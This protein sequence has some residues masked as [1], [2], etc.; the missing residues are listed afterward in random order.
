VAANFGIPLPAGYDTHAV[1]DPIIASIALPPFVPK[2]T[3]IKASEADT[4]V[5]GDDDDPAVVAA[6]SKE[7]SDMA[8]TGGAGGLSGFTLTAAEFEKDDDSNHHIDFI[9]AAAN[10]RARNYR[11]QETT[12]YEVKLTAGKIIPAIATTTC[13]VTGLVCLEAYKA[14]EGK[15]VEAQRNTFMNLAI[16]M[17]SMA[18]PVGPKRTKTVAYDPVALGPI[19]AIPE[20]FTAWDRIH[21]RGQ[22]DITPAALSAWLTAN[23][24][25]VRS[26]MIS[27]GR[28]I[29]Y[30][31]VT[32]R[33]HAARAD[34]PLQELIA[35]VTGH[36]VAAEKGYFI[37][38]VSAED[39][40]GDTVI[41]PVQVYLH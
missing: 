37:V 24:S 35:T 22:P 26:T 29:L 39:D 16:N 23:H 30:S 5:E 8:A 11:I 9:A 21:V 17:F 14:I 28:S 1:M 36:P 7:L 18:E 13:A 25:G 6:V 15:A 33:S 10:L 20:G 3:R 2:S 4:T 41:P 19:K 12:R 27:Y 34:T 32:F 31:P 38:D 40:E